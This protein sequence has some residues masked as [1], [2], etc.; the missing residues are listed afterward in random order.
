M[1]CVSAVL[2]F[3]NFR[4]DDLKKHSSVTS[5]ILGLLLALHTSVQ[6][7][8]ETLPELIDIRHFAEDVVVGSKPGARL[9]KWDHAPTVRLETMAVGSRDAVTGNAI[10]VPIETSEIHYK[11]LGEHIAALSPLI[12]LPIR[13]LPR[14]FGAGGDIVIS[15]VPRSLMSALP[16]PGVPAKM[17]NNLMGPSRCFFVIWPSP[18]WAITKGQIVINSMLDEHH[19]KHCLL[20]ELTQ[21][22]GLPNDS[23]RLRPSVFNETSMVT[24]L[25]ALDR[26]LITTVYDPRIEKGMTLGPFRECAD[27]VI[28][29]HVHQK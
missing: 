21:S 19:I 29:S 15:I 1:P 9:V 28:R 16:F 23:D 26:I 4:A 11:E 27:E 12:S 7:S 3:R 5:A 13:L 14:D 2:F 24:E 6:A 25:T 18:D 22:L 17:L 10:M 20:E 8:A